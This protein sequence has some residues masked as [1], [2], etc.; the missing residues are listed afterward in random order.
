MDASGPDAFW[1]VHCVICRPSGIEELETSRGPDGANNPPVFMPPKKMKIFAALSK[2]PEKAENEQVEAQ[3]TA[4]AIIY[5]N[6]SP[7]GPAKRSS[8]RPCTEITVITV[9]RLK[10]FPPSFQRDV[11]ETSNKIS[12]SQRLRAR[13]VKPIRPLFRQPLH[14]VTFDGRISSTR[15]KS[16]RKR[17][18]H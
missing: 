18:V 14:L 11:C 8:R 3:R 15:T 1:V 13:N 7:P 12:S 9:S 16:K 5:P 4:Q 10:I 2:V 17:K 6:K